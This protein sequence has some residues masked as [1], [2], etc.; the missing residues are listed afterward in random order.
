[1]KPEYG[2]P[3]ATSEIPSLHARSGEE[4]GSAMAV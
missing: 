1:M 3:E 2:F 4:S